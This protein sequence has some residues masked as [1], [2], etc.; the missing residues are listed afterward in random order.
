MSDKRGRGSNLQDG[1][2]VFRSISFDQWPLLQSPTN[3]VRTVSCIP[4]DAWPLF[5][6]DFVKFS[7]PV[8]LISKE[9][10]WCFI[11]ALALEF[12]NGT[13]KRTG[14]GTH[15]GALLMMILDFSCHVA[16]MCMD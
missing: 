8:Y 1:T 7:S 15:G 5:A 13:S 3:F 11:P 2:H 4:V 16:Y 9:L 12:P 6:A 10:E 14:G